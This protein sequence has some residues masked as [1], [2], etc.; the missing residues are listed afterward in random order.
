M[1][2]LLLTLASLCTLHGNAHAQDFAFGGSG[3]DGILTLTFSDGQTTSIGTHTA[4]SGNAP[5][6]QGWWSDTLS[7][8]YRGTNYITGHFADMRW[9]DF[10]V[11]DLAGLSGTVVE[12]SLDLDTAAIAGTVTFSLWDV[13]TPLS[14]LGNLGQGPNAAIYADLGSGILYGGLYAL[15]AADN[16][17]QQRFSLNIDG[18]AAVNTAV[19]GTFAL[20]GSANTNVPEPGTVTLLTIALAILAA[21]RHRRIAAR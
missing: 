21:G 6:T 4:A 1:I 12:A 15:T 14:A 8:T 9:N 7:N 19:G 18:L 10:F 17:Q 11:F 5:A 20:G 3:A 2:K 13:T 16:H